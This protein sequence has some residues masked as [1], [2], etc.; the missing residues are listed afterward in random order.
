M[1]SD[2]FRRVIPSRN[3]Y[4]IVAVMTAV[5]MSGVV[6]T[7]VGEYEDVDYASAFGSGLLASGIVSLILFVME[8]KKERR[9][10]LETLL[11]ITLRFANKIGYARPLNIGCNPNR[12]TLEFYESLFKDLDRFEEVWGKLWFSSC[13][14]D[15]YYTT[16][17]STMGSYCQDLR[18]YW[19]FRSA[20][21]SPDEVYISDIISLQ[22]YVFD[23][24][25]N[26]IMKDSLE[27]ACDR[28]LDQ[29]SRQKV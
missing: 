1:S 2:I 8:S 18:A 11:F 3:Y 14:W 22:T 24:D 13:D 5:T 17:Y 28:L 16:I 12:K 19:D 10:N 15:Y 23:K 7:V 9:Q 29:M 4:P 6:L 21:G 20:K 27:R 25:G 26:N